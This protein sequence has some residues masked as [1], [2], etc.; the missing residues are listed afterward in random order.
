MLVH[1]NDVNVD[2]FFALDDFCLTASKAK[3]K[4]VVAMV[5]GVT[6][7]TMVTAVTM[8]TMVFVYYTYIHTF[9]YMTYKFYKNYQLHTNVHMNHK[10][11]L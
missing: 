6:M 3:S 7:F 5:T 2:K 8:I 10:N 4:R 9:I 11:I 1:T